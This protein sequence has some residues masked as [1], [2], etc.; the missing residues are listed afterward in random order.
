MRLRD[1]TKLAERNRKIKQEYKFLMKKRKTS[2][3]DAFYLLGT[4]YHIS[5]DTVKGI[6]WEK[7]K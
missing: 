6:L 4:K 3:F 5:F 7:N 2:Q 1:K